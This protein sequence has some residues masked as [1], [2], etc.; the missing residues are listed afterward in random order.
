M[1]GAGLSAAWGYGLFAVAT[2][3][4]VGSAALLAVLA[5]T[6]AGDATAL[7]RGSLVLFV[8]G[9]AAYVLAVVAL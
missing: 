4:L 9:A 2:L 1:P 7:G 5:L 3:L 6:R 8:A